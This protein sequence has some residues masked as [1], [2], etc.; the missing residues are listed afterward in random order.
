MLGVVRGVVRGLVPGVVLGRL[1]S[2]HPEVRH[3]AD[4]LPRLIE[5]VTFVKMGIL[6]PMKIRMTPCLS[7]DSLVTSI[8]RL[9]AVGA[10]VGLVAATLAPPALAQSDLAREMEILKRD[11]KD[12]QRYI[13]RGDGASLPSAPAVPPPNAGEPLPN[14]MAGRLQIKIQRLEREM[15]SATGRVEEAEF[16]VRQLDQRMEKLSSDINFRLQRLEQ[17]TGISGGA[18]GT[19]TGGGAL[20][21]SNGGS[22][23]GDQ[24]TT[25]ISSQGASQEAEGQSGSGQPQTLGALRTNSAGEV[26]GADA[27]PQS[28]QS[29][30]APSEPAP[31]ASQAAPQAPPQPG[32]VSG[33]DATAAAATGAL[34]DGTVQ[35]QYDYAFSLLRKRDFAGAE[36]AMRRF[37]DTNG[38]SELAG[39]A[40]YWLGE[41]YYARANYRDAAATFL[42]AYTG[43]PSNDKAS[44]SLLKLAMS[45]GSLGKKDAACQAFSTLQQDGNATQRILATGR[46]E[47]SK[48]GCS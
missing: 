30:N 8:A 5:G 12:L 43:Y 13:Y 21:G 19:N 46:E 27:A 37:V 17:A 26:I 41:T 14:D 11:L 31:S 24:G 10:L 33:A 45:L 15:R 39:N 28:S 18:G 22:A 29:A 38:D 4:K 25:V 6:D 36:G 3:I 23:G 48:L 47:A 9:F 34:P 35:E 7:L 42:D 32:A 16:R 2:G 40:M 20:S 1:G 44:H